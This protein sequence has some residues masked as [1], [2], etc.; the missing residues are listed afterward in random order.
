MKI[1]PNL[2]EK[3]L[4]RFWSKVKICESGCWEWQA[5]KNQD[6]YGQIGIT[7]DSGPIMYQ[8]HRVALF[9]KTGEQG[10]VARHSCDNPGCCNPDHLSWGTHQDNVDD[11][12]NRGRHVQVKG[13]RVITAKLTENDVR[14]IRI[15]GK[16]IGA[17]QLAKSY[18]VALSC[19][20]K[21]INRET[22]KHVE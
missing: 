21:I 12:M 22:W 19:I 2:T 18:G 14:H 6:G 15:N 8:A 13:E 3:D 9:I 5:S 20:Y 11:K 17:K 4:K 1:I 7:R 10:E 16:V